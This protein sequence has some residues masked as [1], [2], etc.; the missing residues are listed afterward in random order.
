M[1]GAWRLWLALALVAA[2]LAGCGGQ[3]EPPPAELAKRAADSLDSLKSVHFVLAIAGAPAFLDASRTLNLRQAEG[4]VL[5]PDRAQATARVA[6]GGFV[7]SVK[8]I[9]I[10][11][12]NYMTDPLGGKWGQAPP[13]LGYNATYLF[14]K[15][16]GAGAIVRQVE[17]IA[18]AGEEKIDGVDCHH[19]TGQIANAKLKVL[20]G[21]VIPGETVTVDV[22]SAKDG[23]SVRQLRLTEIGAAK[24]PMTW[25]LVLSRHD[26]PLTI[27][28]PA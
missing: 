13:G 25:T 26:Q 21:G 12:A 19:L 14:D 20:T 22:W 6:L 8:F 2:V 9:N 3:P 28:A 24:A 15:E 27:E 23:A 1:K 10:G 7:V 18:K 17:G 11:D 5:R 16:Q 4:D